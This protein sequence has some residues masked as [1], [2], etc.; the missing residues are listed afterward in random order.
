[1]RKV[2]MRAFGEPDVLVEEACDVPEPGPGE[3]LLR[4]AGAGVNPIDWKTRRGLGFV[5]EQI[6]DRLPWTPGYD[7]AGVVEAVGPGVEDW[8]TGDRAMGLIG[9]PLGGGGYSSLACVP[10]SMLVEVP[11][12]LDLTVMGAVPLAALTAWQAL[13]EVGRLEAGDKVLIH[14]GAGGVGHF[15]VQFALLKD[16]HVIATG[17][18]D[19]LDLLDDLGAHEVIDYSR[20]NFLDDCYGLD[21]VVDLV[22]GDVGVRSLHTLAEDGQLITVPTNTAARVLSEARQ[23]QLHALGMTVHPDNSQLETIV[24]LLATGDVQVHLEKQYALCGASEAHR[25]LERG[26]VHGKLVLV[27]D[28]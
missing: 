26:H 6:G 21:F 12:E 18:G 27:P 8:Q 15:A 9:F 2:L 4:V 13:F 10:A 23:R 14:A 16:A 22:G 20:E 19:S 3:V 28:L 24:D 25:H 7:V 1:M 11:D 17:S 5:A